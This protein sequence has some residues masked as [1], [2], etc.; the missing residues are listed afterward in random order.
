EPDMV[1]FRATK[2]ARS[3]GPSPRDGS[4]VARS[5]THQDLLHHERRPRIP[6]LAG[7]I[8][9]LGVATWL[10]PFQIPSEASRPSS[11]SGARLE[12]PRRGTSATD[13]AAVR[14]E[15]TLE[16]PR[17]DMTDGSDRTEAIPSEDQGLGCVTAPPGILESPAPPD[18]PRAR[19]DFE[20]GRPDDPT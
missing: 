19:V 12:D 11:P 17:N 18:P 2:P 8:V 5:G 6:W 1:P 15:I 13:A 7:G 10:L 4:A 16:P 3:R 9:S 14:T 20:P